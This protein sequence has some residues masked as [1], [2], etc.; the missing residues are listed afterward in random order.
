[1]QPFQQGRLQPLLNE[2]VCRFLQKAGAK[3]EKK[4]K[5]ISSS[6]IFYLDGLR[7][8][9]DSHNSVCYRVKGDAGAGAIN[10][11]AGHQSQK[12]YG[13]QAIIPNIKSC[14][15]ISRPEPK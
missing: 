12:N 6:Q 1:L 15:K 14:K 9:S 10:G 5:E 8:D 4:G 2:K 13:E 3:Y 7:V 11:P